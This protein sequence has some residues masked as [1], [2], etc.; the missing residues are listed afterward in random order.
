MRQKPRLAKLLLAALCGRLVSWSCGV[1]RKH[2]LAFVG[3][4]RCPCRYQPLGCRL[5]PT[6]GPDSVS[7]EQESETAAESEEPAATNVSTKVAPWDQETVAFSN[8]REA[9]AALASPILLLNWTKQAR[10]MLRMVDATIP[11]VLDTTRA[12]KAAALSTAGP[13][14]VYFIGETGSGKST[15]IKA[16][17]DGIMPDPSVIS[18][19][20]ATGLTLQ[21]TAVPLASGI[22]LVDT[23]GFRIPVPLAATQSQKSLSERLAARI[24]YSR[25][26][27]RWASSVSS[28]QVKV[29][30]TN[31]QLRPPSAVVYVHRA[32]TRIVMERMVEILSVPLSNN[33]PTFLILTDVYAVDDK[34]RIEIRE[35]LM[36]IVDKVGK[37][38]RGQGIFMLEVNSV[39]KF[40]NSRTVEAS[41]LSEFIA[42][43]LNS[44]R[45]ADVLHFAKRHRIYEWPVR[46]DYWSQVFLR[47]V[48]WVLSESLRRRGA[49]A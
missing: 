22:V 11:D 31:P 10:R 2:A 44:L 12:W 13:L 34:D 49:L 18:T 46:K 43:L 29:K 32:G 17:G 39:D 42:A 8:L 37:N 4:A 3:L 24:L 28:L 21:D 5:S 20:A 16:L 1:H 33:I 40:V 47:R 6:S 25:E 19:S 35:T 15:L 7:E 27:A 14:S 38:Q 30:E 48:Q 45:P 36:E 9:K 41:G 23:C 26:L